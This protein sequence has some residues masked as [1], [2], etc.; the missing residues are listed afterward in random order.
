MADETTNSRAVSVRAQQA[1]KFL[2]EVGDGAG[3]GAMLKGKLNR[4]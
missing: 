2:K 4:K 3:L 1:V